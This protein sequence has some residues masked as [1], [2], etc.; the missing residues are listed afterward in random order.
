MR[1]TLLGSFF[2]LSGVSVTLT[3]SR[4]LTLVGG[5][6]LD[7]VEVDD[8]FIKL[9]VFCVCNGFRVEA[10]TFRVLL[11]GAGIRD[12]ITSLRRSLIF[13]WLSCSFIERRSFFS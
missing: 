1:A 6:S 9:E 7:A 10:S 8:G 4:P 12:C 11:V 3:L 13:S 5:E 2:V